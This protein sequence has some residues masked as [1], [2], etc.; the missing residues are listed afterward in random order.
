MAAHITLYGTRNSA[1]CPEACS[2]LLLE[3]IA[4]NRSSS[5]IYLS[6]LLCTR[7]NGWLERCRS[8]ICP[9]RCRSSLSLHPFSLSKLA[10]NSAY[11]EQCAL[12]ITRTFAFAPTIIYFV[13]LVCNCFLR[14]W[15]PCLCVGPG[16]ISVLAA[17]YYIQ[18]KGSLPLHQ[19]P[20]NAYCPAIQY[21]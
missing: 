12:Q 7:V 5:L 15:W 16:A 9:E 6:M 19:C 2:I 4:P 1:S 13:L 14:Y 10:V 21:K 8:V 20:I 17:I 3:R 18:M 11:P